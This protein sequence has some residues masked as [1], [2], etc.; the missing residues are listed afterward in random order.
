MK[1]TLLQEKDPLFV[2][3]VDKAETACATV[4][5]IV[6]YLKAKMAENERVQFITVFDHFT[7][8]RD[9]GGEINPQ[10]KDARDVIF[11]F[12]F[13]LPNPQLLAVRPCAIGIADLGD[14]FVLSFL[15]APMEPAND[16]MESWVH[17]LRN[18]A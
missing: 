7:H 16:A 4:D 15:E 14:R 8:T 6:D 17:G 9:I 10:I 5:H 18:A 3:E 11:C 13:A 2:A 12:G 1:Q